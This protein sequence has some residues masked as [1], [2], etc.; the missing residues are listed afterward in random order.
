[1]AK[2]DSPDEYAAAL[3]KLL[4]DRELATRLAANAR[5]KVADFTYDRRATRLLAA[6]EPAT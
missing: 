4:E 3:R 2:N 5:A 1:M 6:F